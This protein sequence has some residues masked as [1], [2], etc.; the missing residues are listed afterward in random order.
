MKYAIIENRFV[1]ELR[2]QTDPLIIWFDFKSFLAIFLF[3]LREFDS[4]IR[5]K[6][7]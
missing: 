6:S 2:K 3:P 4:R 7:F 1:I 5:L